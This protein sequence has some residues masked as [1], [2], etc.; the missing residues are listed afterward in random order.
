MRIP[1][2]TWD[3]MQKNKA[4]ATKIFFMFFKRKVKKNKEFSF[5]RIFNID[6]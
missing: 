5:D 6:F 3:L 4:H 2:N 1:R